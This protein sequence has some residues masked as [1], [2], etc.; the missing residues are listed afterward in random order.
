MAE[1][2]LAN[3]LAEYRIFVAQAV[4]SQGSWDDLRNELNDPVTG[5]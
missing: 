4:Y 3:D 2:V 1:M 5:G